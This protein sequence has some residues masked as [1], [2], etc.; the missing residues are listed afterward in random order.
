[1]AVSGV[2]HEPEAKALH[3]VSIRAGSGV[4]ASLCRYWMWHTPHVSAACA[5][6]APAA[7]SAD[8]ITSGTILRA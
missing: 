4:E 7:T 1:M 6:A 2:Q 5:P 8:I 3:A